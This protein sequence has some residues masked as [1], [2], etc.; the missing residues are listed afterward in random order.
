MKY[1]SDLP[2]RERQIARRDAKGGKARR[3]SRRIAR[4]D[5]A[6]DAHSE[7]EGSARVGGLPGRTQESSRLQAQHFVFCAYE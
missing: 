3:N 5:E 7:G 6:S 4:Q 1:A 2:P